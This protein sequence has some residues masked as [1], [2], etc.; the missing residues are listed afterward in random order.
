MGI[1]TLSHDQQIYQK[2]KSSEQNVQK[3]GQAHINDVGVEET[4]H[5]V[6]LSPPELQ[7]KVSPAEMTLCK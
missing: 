7:R 2:D 3:I 4:I 1:K 5:Q 6:Q